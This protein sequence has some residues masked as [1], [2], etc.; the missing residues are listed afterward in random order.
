MT[1]RYER[2]RTRI[3]KHMKYKAYRQGW[4]GVA[5]MS[6]GGA[7]AMRSGLLLRSN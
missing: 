1:L 2:L 4:R 7:S 5:A 3:S 6:L